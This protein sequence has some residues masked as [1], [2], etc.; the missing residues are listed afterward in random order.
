M[1]GPRL[2]DAVTLRHFGIT[3]YLGVVEHVLS[4]YPPPH[5]TETVRS[6]ILAG[7]G[8]SQPG[9]S[10]VLA[11]SFLGT[12]HQIPTTDMA[13]VMRIR[14]ALG[15]GSGNSTK[16]LGEA[17]SIFLADRLNG[18]FIT[19]DRVAYDFAL[20]RLGNIRV[21]DTVDLLRETVVTGYFTSSEAQQVADAIRNSGRSLRRGHPSTF[22][23]KYFEP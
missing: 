10:N 17:E 5:W 14:I 6:E 15:G 7:F 1:S 3:E 16:D 23:P 22:T 8:L 4:P 9:C 2:V 21:F 18:T 20:R 12:P 11:A 19:D 13:E